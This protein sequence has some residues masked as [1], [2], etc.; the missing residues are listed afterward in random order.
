MRWS[1]VALLF[2]A[3]LLLAG[4]AGGVQ[5]GTGEQAVPGG[6][7]DVTVDDELRDATGT[8]EVIV[9]VSPA[10]DARSVSDLRAHAS[11]SQEPLVAFA[12][13][14]DGVSV[15]Q[16]FWLGNTVLLTVD[17]D[18]VSLDALAA[19]DGVE[20]LSANGEVRV[21]TTS[22]AAAPATQGLYTGE[23]HVRSDARPSG[24]HN[25]TYGLDQINATEVWDQ[26]GT[27]GEGVSVAVLDTGV[28]A[29][30]PDIDV[31]DWQEF[32]ENGNPENTQPRDNNGHGTHVS[33]T[34]VGG[35]ASGK[36]IGVAP[37]A[38]LYAVKVLDGQSGTGTGTFTQII[39]GMQYAVDQNVD[40]ISMSLGA[41]GYYNQFIDEVRDAEAA[42]TTVVAA[43]GNGGEGT[44]DS[45]GNVYDAISVGASDPL[46]NIA[47]FSSGEQINTL[48]DWGP[49]APPEWP[50]EYVVPS[51]AA[52]GAQ[53]Y[54]A[55][56]GGGYENRWGTSMATPHVSGA[57]ALMESVVPDLG[58]NESE[59]TLEETARK[60]D[61]WSGPDDARDTRYGSGIID[62]LAALD[63]FTAGPALVLDSVTAPAEVDP[64]GSL[65]VD[66]AITNVGDAEG[67]ESTV[68]L[69]VDGTGQNAD[70]TDTGVT[71][72]PNETGTGTLTLDSVNASF[73]PG[74]T[75][76]WT[77]ELTDFDDSAGGTTN[78]DA[79]PASFAVDIVS[80][81]EPVAGDS[82]S[83]TAGIENTGDL[84]DTQTITL[85]VPGLG[86]DATQVTLNGRNSTDETL[87]VGT[88]AGD[89]GEYTA[90]VASENDTASADVTV[91]EPASFALDLVAAP[92][93]VDSRDLT[94]TVGVE[95]TGE[96]EATQTVTLDVPGLGSDSTD[97]TLGGGEST[98]TSL[99]VSPTSG[100]TGEYT[101]TV[102]SEDDTVSTNVT[103][104]PKGTFLVSVVDVDAPIGGGTLEVTAGVDNTGDQEQSRT[105]G[106]E[107]SG[108]GSNATNVTLGGGASTTVPLGVETTT[109]D[110]GEYT[111]SL[112]SR[113]DTISQPVSLGPPP[114]AAS[115]GAPTDPDGDGVYEDTDGNGAFDIFDVQVLFVSLDDPVV[116]DYP[117][118]FDFGGDDTV[119]IV[120]VQ[121]LFDE[122]D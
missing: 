55:K 43:A 22:P 72:G 106:L 73:D 57:L 79:V 105:I 8:V 20:S 39:A 107:L 35:D 86:S 112:T 63:S 122:L 121:A 115:Q 62:V 96:V 101:A 15:E 69:R 93:T 1:T 19:V 32:D 36:N 109:N 100:G 118:A 113:N 68:A 87:G 95:N 111:A 104:H 34:V 99:S 92:N 67:T 66:Y 102:E 44:S 82:L 54:S 10:A 7:A 103:V 23:V 13:R 38:D 42:G 77:V 75:I 33:G 78:V 59:T 41:E 119:G 64:D 3:G 90:T 110:T 94:V 27:Q 98:N 51:V 6:T 71:V 4:A 14:T 46:R 97:L 17:T 18:Q 49:T 28:D 114:L 58:P 45:P 61:S 47:N 11:A 40:I 89:A 30:H 84:E 48:S 52:P 117:A 88:G 120:D 25:P 5:H 12:A 116:T 31:A 85:D 80:V 81:T 9:G 56:T 53:V 83:V 60:P 29:S 70:D 26:Y 16:Q 2:V 76:S 50:A 65:S 21:Q 24:S 74:D 37:G 108:V 91:L